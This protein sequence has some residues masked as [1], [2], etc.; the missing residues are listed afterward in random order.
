MWSRQ[1][2]DLALEP[3][4]HL[5]GFTIGVQVTNLNPPLTI[6][7]GKDSAWQDR[8]SASDRRHRPSDWSVG[9]W[10]VRIDGG[11]NQNRWGRFIMKPYAG[12]SLQLEPPSLIHPPVWIHWRYTLINYEIQ[13]TNLNPQWAVIINTRLEANCEKRAM[14]LSG[15]S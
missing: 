5:S 2:N 14:R 6:S 11:G 12:S 13:V 3:Y 7:I 8:N 9:V 10:I 4:K 1:E 15:V